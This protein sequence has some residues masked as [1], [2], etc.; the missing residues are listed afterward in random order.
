MIQLLSIIIEYDTYLPSCVDVIQARSLIR[1]WYLACL[2][3]L[4][5]FIFLMVLAG[6]VSSE[7]WVSLPDLTQGLAGLMFSVKRLVKDGVWQVIVGSE[8]WEVCIQDLKWTES[9]N[10]CLPKCLQYQ[11]VVYLSWFRAV[12]HPFKMCFVFRCGQEHKGHLGAIS[13]RFSQE[14]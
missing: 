11:I 9:W 10:E 14:A 1:D 8:A 4:A 2:R 3:C 6:M 12:G 5:S 13:C 7:I